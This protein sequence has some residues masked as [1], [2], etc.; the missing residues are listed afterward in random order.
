MGFMMPKAPAAPQ[1]PAVQAL[2]PDPGGQEAAREASF[3]QS[4]MRARQGAAANVLTGPNGIPGARTT[5]QLGQA[6]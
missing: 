6:A 1:R 3:A 4:L 2:V 5:R